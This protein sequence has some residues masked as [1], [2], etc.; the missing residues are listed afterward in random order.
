MDVNASIPEHKLLA[1][2]I[3]AQARVLVPTCQLLRHAPGCTVAEPRTTEGWRLGAPPVHI[4]RMA[5]EYF[6][7]S[8]VIELTTLSKVLLESVPVEYNVGELQNR[9]LDKIN[10]KHTTFHTDHVLRPS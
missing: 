9:W 10:L 3:S 8:A 6:E 5:L 7:G 4:V 1:R 2:K